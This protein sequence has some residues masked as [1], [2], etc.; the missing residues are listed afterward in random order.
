MFLPST[1]T[2]KF[3]DSGDFVAEL[4]RRLVIVGCFN[5]SALNGMFDGLTVNAVTSFQGKHGIHADGVAGPE[6]LRRLNGV[7]SGD[8]GGAPP[9]DTK[10]EEPQIT[11]Q[12]PTQQFVWGQAPIDPIAQQSMMASAETV[13][14]AVA[15]TQP[16]PVS[17]PPPPQEI[18]PAQPPM[19]PP[20]AAPEPTGYDMLAALVQQTSAQ[21]AQGQTPVSQRPP[22]TSPTA[23]TAPMVNPAHGQPSQNHVVQNQQPSAEPEP[24][25]FMGKAIRFANAMMQRLADYFES[26]L[27]P[28]VLHEVKSIGHAMAHQ[29]VREI[30]IPMEPQ[31]AR[32]TELPG[33]GQEQVPRRG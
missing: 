21:Q 6:T 18:R 26:K 27:P 13:T 4:Q 23:G 15:P 28:S 2:L 31:P 24:Q 8:T 19:P 1:I 3:G 33:R 7:I 30:P 22:L 10:P 17:S 16:A 11:T 9:S 14:A 20:A 32:T 29:G 12:Q 25:G 5:E